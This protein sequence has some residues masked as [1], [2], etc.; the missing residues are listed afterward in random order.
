MQVEWDCRIGHGGNCEISVST[1]QVATGAGQGTP[2]AGSFVDVAGGPFACCAQR[3]NEQKTVTIPANAAG[4]DAV[5]AWMWTGDGPYFDCSDITINA[6]EPPSTNQGTTEGG[7]GTGPDAEQVSNALIAAAAVIYG[8]LFLFV[9]YYCFY[10]KSKEDMNV[11]GTGP[12][13]G[14]VS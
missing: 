4:G 8:V 2:G 10:C 7:G 3:G 6:A 11:S 12:N 9:L 14:H 13:G 1:E 5:L